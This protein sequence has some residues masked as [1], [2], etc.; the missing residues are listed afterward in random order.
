MQ[1]SHDIHVISHVKSSL[2]LN[3]MVKHWPPD[4]TSREVLCC[5]QYNLCKTANP[6][7]RQSKDIVTNGSFMEVGRFAECS[8]GAFGNTFDLQ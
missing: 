2:F 5:I 6:K 7:K 1:T 4:D 8:H 3:W